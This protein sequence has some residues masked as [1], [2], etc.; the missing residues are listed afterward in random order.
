MKPLHIELRK[1][2][3]W[4]CRASVSVASYCRPW[5][6]SHWV[7]DLVA[8]SCLVLAVQLSLNGNTVSDNK[9]IKKIYIYLLLGLCFYQDCGVNLIFPLISHITTE[10]PLTVCDCVNTANQQT[11]TGMSL[12]WINIYSS[13]KYCGAVVKGGCANLEF[14]LL[15]LIVLIWNPVVIA[16][17]ATELTS[18]VGKRSL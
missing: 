7:G 8:V 4:K 2:S 11:V 12:F 9:N 16:M 17:W 1:K 5:A 6:H 3:T 18:V 13:Y 14:R 15:I 10:F